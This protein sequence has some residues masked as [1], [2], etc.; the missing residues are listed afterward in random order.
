MFNIEKNLKHC[1]K[2]KISITRALIVGFLITG[3]LAYGID[4]GENLE[5]NDSAI[6]DGVKIISP[7]LKIINDGYIGNTSTPTAT[8][9]G[10]GINTL[11]NG[12]AELSNYGIISGDVSGLTSP[13]T[14]GTTNY[15]MGNGIGFNSSIS[16]PNN[17]IGKLENRGLIKGKGNIDASPRT[18]YYAATVGNGVGLNSNDTKV[19]NKIFQTGNISNQGMIEGNFKFESGNNTLLSSRASG[20]GV[21]FHATNSGIKTVFGGIN[22]SGRILGNSIILG[23]KG[24]EFRGNG[25]GIS[26]F[27]N[28]NE[29]LSL[30]NFNGVDNKGIISGN[31]ELEIGEISGGSIYAMGIGIN[32]YSG[33]SSNQIDIGNIN[34]SGII[35]GS[36][37]L[38]GNTAHLVRTA[39]NGVS[40]FGGSSSTIIGQIINTGTI[41]GYYS[42]DS[43]VSAEYE[44]AGNGVYS[45]GKIEGIENSGIIAGNN[46]AIYARGSSSSYP[47]GD[48]NNYGIL[49][50]KTISNKTI[51][52]QGV[53]IT[54][55]EVG[56]VKSVVNGSGGKSSAGKVII[57]TDIQGNDS[58]LDADS[59][60]SNNI[61]NGVGNKNGV[62]NVDKNTIV[63]NS[64]INA[65]KTAVSLNEGASLNAINTVFNGGGLNGEEATIKIKGNNSILQIKES[66]IINGDISVD[67]NNSSLVIDN[68]TLLNGNLITGDSTIGNTLFLGTGNTDK[69]LSIFGKIESFENIV[70]RGNVTL[71]ETASLEKGDIHIENGQ[72]GIRID[73]TK[74]LD[75]KVIGHA[76]YSH[77][78]T[79]SANSDSEEMS[80]IMDSGA[81]LVFKTSGLLDGTIIDMNGTDLNLGDSQI[82][83]DSIKHTAIISNGD[84]KIAQENLTG[85]I[86]SGSKFP[87][88]G[89]DELPNIP[90]VDNSESIGGINKISK[91]AK[92]EAILKGIYE[93]ENSTKME[94]LRPTY[95]YG[96][97]SGK[98][99]EDAINGLI[100]ILDQVYLNNPY[101]FVGEASRDNIRLYREGIDFNNLMPKEK[102]TITTGQFLY[103]NNKMD[104]LEVSNSLYGKIDNTKYE[105]TINTNGILGTVEYGTS[106]GR[107]LGLALGGG[108]QELSMEG[109]SSLEADSMYIGAFYKIKEKTKRRDEESRVGI[110]YQLNKYNARRAMEN[111]YQSIIEKSDFDTKSFDL[112]WEGKAL[113]K[114]VDGW[115]IEPKLKLSYVHVMQD[116]ISEKKGKLPIYVEQENYNYLDI[117]PGID[118]NKIISTD[119]GKIKIVFSGSYINTHGTSNEDLKAKFRDGE[120]QFEIL[121]PTLGRDSVKFGLGI[122]Y[123]KNNGI[124]YGISTNLKIGE[125]SGRDVDLIIKGGYKF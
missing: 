50:G 6:I 33:S 84:V 11:G 63:S 85:I 9:N 99:R 1:L 124:N 30:K 53:S 67:G 20:N 87:L 81:S 27:T 26:L 57:N 92:L 3:S 123:E 69:N 117:E 79:I 122:N 110:G 120:S 48:L 104:D 77:T 54:I 116:S 95:V 113:L 35:S 38:I 90:E 96:L 2:G 43:T 40:A 47:S 114:E 23:N 42:P 86:N 61:I 121:S 31:N 56:N 111:E 28:G 41:K 13:G 22:N 119:N 97:D 14:S 66:S 102:E 73:G 108:T 98:T 60:Y 24:K 4:L 21:A 72:L 101:S 45:Y 39:G 76:L 32:G 89:S 105:K 17:F 93:V 94:Y 78:G 12:F 83:T 109:N 52:N 80:R 36:S 100:Q 49:T 75:G 25:N 51:N 34:N 70:T 112:Y 71:Y 8:E 125:E 55:D 15:N 37:K 65:Y 18:E 91:L 115:R 68:E 82:G 10:N 64:I 19:T 62:L 103:S 106:K 46:Y 44:S 5:Y 7:N 59:I 29:N 16:S 107:A 118:I 74:T 88:P 58:S